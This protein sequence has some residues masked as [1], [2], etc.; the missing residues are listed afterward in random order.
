MWRGQRFSPP[1]QEDLMDGN[2]VAAVVA[3]YPAASWPRLVT[4]S[5]AAVVAIAFFVNTALPYLMLDQDAMAR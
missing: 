2:R 4:I 3:P 5:V 1:R